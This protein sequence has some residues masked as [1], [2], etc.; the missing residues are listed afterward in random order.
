MVLFNTCLLNRRDLC[1]GHFK[2]KLKLFAINF[3]LNL[4]Q[5]YSRMEKKR[6]LT[7]KLR[8]FNQLI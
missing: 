3:T 6:M 1:N 8:Y 7:R 4:L 5:T 2:F